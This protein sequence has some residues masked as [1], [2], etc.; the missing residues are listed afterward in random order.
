M[1]TTAH[2]LIV[3]EG[4]NKFAA[5]R[6]VEQVPTNMLVTPEA[7]EDYEKTKAYAQ[8][9]EANFRH[10]AETGTGGGGA[11]TLPLEAQGHDTVGAVA[12]DSEGNIAAVSHIALRV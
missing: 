6:G 8:G 9:V 10:T 2:C 11:S 4:A 7:R 3:G 12:M 1:D 5:K